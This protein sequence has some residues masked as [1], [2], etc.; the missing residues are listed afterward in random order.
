MKN[1]LA[2]ILLASL[3]VVHAAEVVRTVHPQPDVVIAERVLTSGHA[4]E[5]QAAIDAVAK[6]G[7]GTVFLAK[8]RY[9]IDAPVTVKRGVTLRGDYARD[10]P[11]ESTVLAIV[12]GA[13]EEEGTAAFSLEHGS[14]LVGLVFYYPHQTL[15]RPTPYPWTVRTSLRHAGNNQTVQDCTFVN[16]WRAI[17]I[18]PE[19]NECHTLRHLRICALKTGLFV[20]MTTDIGRVYDVMIEP[21]VWAQGDWPEGTPRHEELQAYLKRSGAVAVDYARSDWE[22]IRDLYVHGYHTGIRFRQ[23]LRG[24]MNGVMAR[25][26]ITRCDEALRLDDLNE[27]GLSAYGLMLNDNATNIIGSATFAGL[28]QFHSCIVSGGRIAS[29][30]KGTLNLRNSYRPDCQALRSFGILEAPG[31]GRILSDGLTEP[32]GFGVAMPEMP[33]ARPAGDA[34]VFATVDTQAEDCTAAIQAA[35]DAAAKEPQGATVYLPAGIYRCRG[36]LKVPA[37]VELRGASAVPHHTM[38]GGTVFFVYGGRGTE[39]GD[40]FCSLAPG[41][42][43]RGVS[44]WY[45]EQDVGA[46]VA[47]P[48]T[49]RALGPDC[50]LTDVNIANS[51]RGA[52]FATHPS[53]RHRISYLSGA[54][55]RTGL[56]VGQCATEGWVEDVQMNPHYVYRRPADHP[57]KEPKERGPGEPAFM[58]YQRDW[59]EGLVFTDCAAEYIT[60]T[61]LYAAR[62]GLVFRGKMDANVLIHGTDTGC[63]ALTV[64]TT[65]GSRVRGALFQLVALGRQVESSISIPAGNAGDLTL[66]ASQFWPQYPI[67]DQHG[68][69]HT[70]LDQFNGVAGP[71]KV[72]AGSAEILGGYF[73]RPH[74]G[75]CVE[76]YG[77]A[78]V[79]ERD[80]VHK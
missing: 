26:S 35:L 27:V 57:L 1:L 65:K 51:W 70:V 74:R 25:G 12:C 42:G 45:P 78:R 77:S 11:T 43:L 80:C 61:F 47:Y 23:G 13:G 28:A 54:C 60:G 10:A 8:G 37:G 34:V 41:A 5:I 76:T 3:S 49:V 20:D 58:L 56:Q 39:A 71:A 19:T 4:A 15:A 40:A 16:S 32:E 72:Y 38:S 52:D 44:F 50:W 75:P 79:T 22:Y 30:P 48:W 2:L 36:S 18:G 53:D 24:S 59:L 9:T 64:E 55:Y 68:T 46:P 73:Q 29:G 21:W 63:R 62:D 33:F 31:P 14:G 6:L 66:Y 69:G 17:A 7:G 67:L